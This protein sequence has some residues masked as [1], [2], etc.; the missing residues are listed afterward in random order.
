MSNKT[1]AKQNTPKIVFKTKLVK[2]SKPKFNSKIQFKNIKF[3]IQIKK[4]ANQKTNQTSSDEISSS[5]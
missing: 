2:I 1:P 3:K 4:K 5:S